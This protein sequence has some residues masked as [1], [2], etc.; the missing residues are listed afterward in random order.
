MNFLFYSKILYSVPILIYLSLNIPLLTANDTNI[1]LFS[2]FGITYVFSLLLFLYSDSFVPFSLIHFIT[3][4]EISTLTYLGFSNK[5]TILIY[6]SFL[7]LLQG[8]KSL[9]NNTVNIFSNIALN[10]SAFLCIFYFFDKSL[11]YLE[12]I[13]TTGLILILGS[14]LGIDILL[15][16]LESK[17]ILV[18]NKVKEIE[19]YVAV[20]NKKDDIYYNQLLSENKTAQE[21]IYFLEKEKNNLLVQVDNNNKEIENLK[22]FNFQKQELNQEI[23][24]AYFYLIANI[25]FDLNETFNENLKRVLTVFN[26]TTNSFFSAVFVYNE[27]KNKLSLE[28]IEKTD[29]N[30]FSDDIFISNKDVNQFLQKSFCDNKIMYQKDITDKD[31]FPIDNIVYIPISNNKIKKGILVQAFNNNIE[32]NI[33]HYNLSLM[34]AY[35]IFFALENEVLYKQAQNDVYMDGLTKVYNKKYLIDKLPIII[36]EADNFNNTLGLV[37]VDIDYFKQVNDTYGHDKGDE[38]LKEISELLKNN[39]RQSDIVFRYGGDEFIVLFLG[40]QIDTIAVFAEA[41]NKT[42]L[43]RNY[44]VL[45]NNEEKNISLSMGC[46]IYEPQS[47]NTST[48]LLEQAD[49]ALY[50]SKKKG[51]GQLNFYKKIEKDSY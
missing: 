1:L 3:I 32:K 23:I 22:N 4:T 10:I 2:V 13:N 46:T 18:K 28:R 31:L 44:K 27:E 36:K 33:H 20:E 9:R 37:F 35:Q 17:N 45:V 26:H 34:M 25:R 11:N 16:I 38:M 29:Q 50:F 30:H 43:N 39:I 42:L 14:I 21:R 15:S 49:Q 7:V 19:K 41:V 5:N 48:E 6:L 40:G 8:I 47:G 24:K 51:K 12:L